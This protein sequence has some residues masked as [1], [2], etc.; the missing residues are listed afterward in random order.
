MGKI[1]DISSSLMFNDFP[2]DGPW[3]A[4][5][6]LDKTLWEWIKFWLAGA[7]RKRPESVDGSLRCWTPSC[8]TIGCCLSMSLH[9]CLD[10]CW[11]W[12]SCGLLCEEHL[13]RGSDIRRWGCM[14]LYVVSSPCFD[15]CFLDGDDD[16]IL[17]RVG[18]GEGW[19]DDLLCFSVRAGLEEDFKNKLG[20]SVTKIYYNKIIRVSLFSV[21]YPK[22]I[23]QNNW[24]S[25]WVHLSEVRKW[26]VSKAVSPSFSKGP[27]HAYVTS[28][29]S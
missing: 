12:R 3:V 25:T 13:L 18:E 27:K 7:N 9:V 21:L 5:F 11:V 4:L 19:L 23:N 8:H 29:T 16:D 28:S 15:N 2:M 6:T 17:W 10:F 1:S 24:E 22:D 20:R 14:V 26:R